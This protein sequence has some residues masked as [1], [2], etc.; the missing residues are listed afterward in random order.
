MLL[1]VISVQLQ[2]VRACVCV[3]VCLC[4]TVPSPPSLTQKPTACSWYRKS[5]AAVCAYTFVS[6]C[7]CVHVCYVHV[8]IC[9][10][11]CVFE[12]FYVCVCVYAYA[13]KI[14]TNVLTLGNSACAT[15][16]SS[17]NTKAL[18][19]NVRSIYRC[20]TRECFASTC[21]LWG[22]QPVRLGAP[23]QHGCPAP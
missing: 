5:P 22:T 4:A 2:C 10:Y 9:V 7:T 18:V 21:S 1:G 12:C 6:L 8:C 11:A 23:R 16:R 3:C 15:G 17:H 14:C 19:V 13:I 20:T